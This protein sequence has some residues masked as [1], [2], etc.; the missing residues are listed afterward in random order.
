MTV[1]HVS[2]ANQQMVE[3]VYISHRMDEIFALSD[4]NTVLR[5]GSYR[6]A[7]TTANMHED[8]VTRLMIGC[9]L[10]L[11]RNEATPKFGDKMLEVRNLSY[12]GLFEAVSFSVLSGEVVG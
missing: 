9:S 6:G 8:E 4:R 7:L 3:I 12:P 5:N 11:S 2:I 1:A 10:D